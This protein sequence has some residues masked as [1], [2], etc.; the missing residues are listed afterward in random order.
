VT[1]LAKAS[2]VEES[3]SVNE[4]RQEGQSWLK[5]H[6][7]EATRTRDLLNAISYSLSSPLGA[8]H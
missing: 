5:R 1:A 6:R 8:S 3:A 4:P 7:R 2:V